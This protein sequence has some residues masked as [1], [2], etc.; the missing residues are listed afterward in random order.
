[1]ERILEKAYLIET[2]FQ[3]NETILTNQNNYN[4]NK[5]V[6]YLIEIRDN[7]KD[8]NFSEIIYTIE[9][10]IYEFTIYTKTLKEDMEYEFEIAQICI[11]NLNKTKEII[12]KN[13]YI[14]V[15]YDFDSIALLNEKFNNFNLDVIYI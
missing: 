5:L 1:M 11:D 7:D 13:K 2:I 4:I 9:D 14:S 10:L 6:N 8:F 15:N 12:K 3:L